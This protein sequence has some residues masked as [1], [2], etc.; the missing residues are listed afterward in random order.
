LCHGSSFHTSAGFSDFS[1]RGNIP[2]LTTTKPSETLLLPNKIEIL[3]GI[4]KRA[5]DVIQ[6]SLVIALFF[7]IS[8]AVFTGLLACVPISCY[9]RCAAPMNN[10]TQ[11]PISQ[12]HKFSRQKPPSGSEL[13]TR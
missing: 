13:Q 5:L 3:S 2:E 12:L 8:A 11:N 1:Q 9:S 7:C 6:D 4:K 10:G